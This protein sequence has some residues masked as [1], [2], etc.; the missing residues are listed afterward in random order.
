M[1]FVVHAYEIIFE[2]NLL[3]LPCE[4]H[5]KYKWFSEEALIEYEKCICIFSGVFKKINKL[6]LA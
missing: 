1:Y 3:F 6:M 4:Q 2:G 5:S